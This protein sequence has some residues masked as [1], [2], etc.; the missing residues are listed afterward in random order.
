M[1]TVASGSSAAVSTPR[2][3]K[4]CAGVSCPPPGLHVSLLQHTC[5]KLSSRS[6]AVRERLTHLN[7][8]WPGERRK[9]A[10][11]QCCCSCYYL[12]CLG[13]TNEGNYC[14]SCM[15]EDWMVITKEGESNYCK[16]LYLWL[17]NRKSWSIF[18]IQIHLYRMV[19]CKFSVCAATSN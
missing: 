14:S 6:S 2:Q 1:L 3:R 8:M 19:F 12:T 18:L 15:P 9:R 17:W 4:G 5:F 7:Q 13:L 11:S 10:L 16:L